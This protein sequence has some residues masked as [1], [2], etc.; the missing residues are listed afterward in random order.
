MSRERRPLFAS[1][2]PEA[3]PGRYGCSML[4]RTRFKLNPEDRLPVMR[5]SLGWA[6]HNELEVARC[7]AVNAMTD[8][9]KVHPERS[10]IIVHLLAADQAVVADD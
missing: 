10:P 8:C 6:L 3:E 4:V 9:W 2:E 1:E 7:M 5:C